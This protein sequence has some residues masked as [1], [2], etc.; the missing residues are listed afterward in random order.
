VQD[1]K[2]GAGNILIAEGTVVTEDIINLAEQHNRFV[3]LSQC[4]K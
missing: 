4:A 1:I 2:D 3:E